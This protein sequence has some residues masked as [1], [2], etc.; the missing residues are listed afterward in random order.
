[1]SSVIVDGLASGGGNRVPWKKVR[2]RL[3]HPKQHMGGDGGSMAP[4]G[5]HTRQQ[6]RAALGILARIALRSRLAT[7]PP[8]TSCAPPPDLCSHHHRVATYNWV[9]WLAFFIPCVR[10]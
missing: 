8:V 5:R 10:W 9:D 4:R 6:R 3:S 1:M 2:G 7:P